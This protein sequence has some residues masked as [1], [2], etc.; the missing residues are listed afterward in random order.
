MRLAPSR[1]R[2][3]ASV[4][5]FPPGNDPPQPFLTDLADAL[6]ARGHVVTGRRI[7]QLPFGLA[8]VLVVNWPE[9]LAA[10]A[11]PGALARTALYLLRLGIGRVRGER[12]VFVW[13]NT[14]PHDLVHPWLQ[15]R[16]LRLTARASSAVVFLSAHSRAEV[17]A[18]LPAISSTSHVIP[19]AVTLAPRAERSAD[20]AP[21][22]P[23]R[24][25]W[26]GLLRRYK[27]LD[28]LLSAHRQLPD[29]TAELRVLANPGSDTGLVAEMSALAAADAD[30]RW[31]R[32]D[33]AELDDALAWADLAVFPFTAITN[34]S[35][36]M[37]A[38]SHHCPV[39]MPNGA[40][41]Q[42][43]ASTAGDGVRTYD[44]ALTPEAL[45][46]AATSA[47]QSEDRVDWS[48]LDRLTWDC[49]GRQ[50]SDLMQSLTR[51]Q[52]GATT[53]ADTEAT[54]TSP[55]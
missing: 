32:F 44:G 37:T 6:R 38:L 34:S 7:R 46:D 27:G 9:N 12:V 26:F 50:W 51:R 42:E 2:G 41:A 19:F 15:E 53:D 35:S 52:P 25:V 1:R 5:I 11:L 39:L 48:W 21:D 31:R 54:R 24:L 40:L 49:I 45:L 14:D 18:R 43:L 8:D 13:H 28:A 10:V 3:L 23:A 30:C 4:A 20:D 17:V 33:D 36:V 55:R 16:L 22:R 29:R 47:R